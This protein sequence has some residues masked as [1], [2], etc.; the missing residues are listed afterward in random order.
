MRE[1]RMQLEDLFATMWAHIIGTERVG[2]HDKFFDIG[3]DSLAA[4]DLI[5]G[6]EQVTGRRLTIAAALFQAP[7]IKQ[8]TTFINQPDPE[9]QP[10][11]V[12]ILRRGSQRPFFRVGAGPRYLSLAWHLSTDLDWKLGRGGVITGEFDVVEIQGGHS[13]VGRT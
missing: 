4:V 13:D 3:G 9:W 10:Y 12:P 11:V 2:L 6:M 1:S 7:T 8:L 5:A